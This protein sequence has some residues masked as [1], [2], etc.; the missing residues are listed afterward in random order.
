MAQLKAAL[1]AVAAEYIRTAPPEVY[2]DFPDF[3]AELEPMLTNSTPAQIQGIMAS[4]EGEASS[5]SVGFALRAFNAALEVHKTWC[6][7]GAAGADAAAFVADFG[8]FAPQAPQTQLEQLMAD[9]PLEVAAAFPDFE[10]ELRAM[11]EK[12]VDELCSTVSQLEK[13]LANLVEGRLFSESEAQQAAN[14]E[15]QALSFSIRA[16]TAAIH[17]AEALDDVGGLH[18]VMSAKALR[19]KATSPLPKHG[20]ETAEAAEEEEQEYAYLNPVAATRPML[21]HE[22]SELQALLP[23]A[24]DALKLEGME[25][26]LDDDTSASA[27]ALAHD[28]S[29]STAGTGPSWYM[30]DIA[31]FDSPGD[32][33]CGR[34]VSPFCFKP[35]KCGE[36]SPTAPNCF[37]PQ[38]RPSAQPAIAMPAMVW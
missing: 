1:S 23:G 27:P 22:L 10:R 19:G 32:T 28:T 11:L 8:T 30:C 29:S 16:M 12:P 36:E 7:M 33:G 17:E 37:T 25:V 35:Q 38:L 14:V 5:L 21:P 20:L 13:A 31:G 4:L 3:S 24:L 6:R 26:E 34:N 2:R 18:R 9:P 15:A